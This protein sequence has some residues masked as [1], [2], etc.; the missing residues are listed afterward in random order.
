[1]SAVPQL[2][3]LQTNA[4]TITHIC[5]KDSLEKLF[6]QIPPPLSL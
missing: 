3:T 1:M 2:V 6:A 5:M 4:I